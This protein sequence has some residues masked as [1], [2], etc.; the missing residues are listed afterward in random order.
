MKERLITALEETLAANRDGDT[1]NLIFQSE[2]LPLREAAANSLREWAERRGLCLVEIDEDND[3]WI[4]EVPNRVLFDRLSRPNTVLLIKNY[5]TVN[6]MDIEK[7]NPRCFLR[8]L[9][10]HRHYGCGNDW[11]PSDDLPDLLFIV[12]INDAIDMYWDA[13]ERAS[14]KPAC[15]E[16]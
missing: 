10:L 9:V 16:G 13:K 15:Q 12:A 11:F 6:W 2:N 7:Y 14:F 5:A 3:A 1:Q 8:D 4:S